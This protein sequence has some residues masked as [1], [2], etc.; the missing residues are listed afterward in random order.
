MNN[1]T[2]VSMRDRVSEAPK[3]LYGFIYDIPKDSGLMNADLV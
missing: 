1:V 2:H 3:E